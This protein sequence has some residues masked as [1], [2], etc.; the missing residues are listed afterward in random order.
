MNYTTMTYAPVH[1]KDA[2]PKKWFEILH[3]QVKKRYIDIKLFVELCGL[4]K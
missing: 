4:F 1:L 2:T 3:L